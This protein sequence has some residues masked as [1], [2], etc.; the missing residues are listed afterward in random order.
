MDNKIGLENILRAELTLLSRQILQDVHQKDLKELYHSVRKLHEK[1][2]A[3]KILSEQLTNDEI[4]SIIQPDTYNNKEEIIIDKKKEKLI[5]VPSAT[6]KVEVK[7]IIKMPIETPRS[8]REK[9]DDIFKE[10]ANITFVKKEKPSPNISKKT[11]SSTAKDIVKK[12]ENPTKTNTES[13]KDMSI[14][15]NDRI[16][17]ISNLFDGNGSEYNA[18]ID[19]LNQ[20]NRYE[21]A[22]KVIYNEIKPKYN[23]WEGKDQYEFRLLQLLELKFN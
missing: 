23:N 18:A 12:I 17:F 15:L 20:C 10:V 6:E 1:M 13:N 2:A 14:G 16:A 21:S 3:I 19:K 9:V 7:E 5:E 22:L 11:N 4:V 8:E